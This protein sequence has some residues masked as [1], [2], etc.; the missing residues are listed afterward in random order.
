M[1]M[2]NSFIG[3]IEN[4]NKNIFGIHNETALTEL[5][6]WIREYQKNPKYHYISSK[7]FR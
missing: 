4:N 3:S 5:I 6:D 2:I 7:R 1:K